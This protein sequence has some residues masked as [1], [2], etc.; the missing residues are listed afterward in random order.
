MNMK[1]IQ[2]AYIE[3]DFLLSSSSIKSFDIVVLNGVLAS[4][5]KNIENEL[6]EY[7]KEGGIMI[8]ILNPEAFYEQIPF[9]DL[10]PATVKFSD[11]FVKIIPKNYAK[12]VTLLGPNGNLTV[13]LTNYFNGTILYITT[14]R[15]MYS[16]GEWWDSS[17]YKSAEAFWDKLFRIILNK[18]KALKII[19]AESCKYVSIIFFAIPFLFIKQILRENLE[20]RKNKTE[21]VIQINIRKKYIS[22]IAVFLLYLLIGLLIVRFQLDNDVPL[23][24]EILMYAG[25]VQCVSNYI[26]KFKSPPSWNTYWWF[27]QPID[28]SLTYYKIYTLLLAP[29]AN[30]I[31]AISTVK[32]MLIISLALGS[33]GTYLVALYFIKNPYLSIFSGIFYEINV[34]TFIEILLWGHLEIAMGYAFSPFVF[35]MLLKLA[36]YSYNRKIKDIIYT[37]SIYGVLASLLLLTQSE[38]RTIIY[39]IILVVMPFFI[40]EFIIIFSTDKKYFL[41]ILTSFIVFLLHIGLIVY[42]LYYI[43]LM[44]HSVYFFISPTKKH[45]SLDITIGYTPTLLQSMACLG[46]GVGH[47]AKYEALG[48]DIGNALLSFLPISLTLF[49]IISFDRKM[50]FLLGS[51]IWSILVTS[52]IYSPI[53]KPYVLLFQY[54]PYIQFMKVPFRNLQSI[55]F[56][57]S[58]LFVNGLG[59]FI[60]ILS[61]IFKFKQFRLV[62]LSIIILATLLFFL[63]DYILIYDPYY[64]RSFSKIPSDVHVL[65]DIM[66]IIYEDGNEGTILFIPIYGSPISLFNEIPDYRS[67]VPFSTCPWQTGL[68]ASFYAAKWSLRTAVGANAL[69]QGLFRTN[70]YLG[71][72]VGPAFFYGFKKQFIEGLSNMFTIKY[73]II[74]KKIIPKIYIQMVEQL[75]AQNIL[76]KLY[77]DEN[78]ILLKIKNV[79]NIDRY[80]LISS[81]PLIIYSGS[82]LHGIEE[83]SF[84][85]INSTGTPYI[86][87]PDPIDRIDVSEFEKLINN[88]K[89]LVIQ[90]SSF[91]DLITYFTII[92]LSSR[93]KIIRIPLESES[94]DLWRPSAYWQPAFDA[95]CAGTAKIGNLT[96]MLNHIEK[97]D[98]IIL[99]RLFNAPFRGKL[100]IILDGKII[101]HSRPNETLGFSYITIGPLREAKILQLFNEESAPN[102]I[103]ELFIIN[104]KDYLISRKSIEEKLKRLLSDRSLDVCYIYHPS[105]FRRVGYT[106]ETSYW[107]GKDETYPPVASSLVL[108]PDSMIEK[109]FYVF[110]NDTL[111]ITLYL[112]A[113]SKE[114][115]KL[116]PR[117]RLEI[118][119]D[120]RTY[121]ILSIEFINETFKW[122]PINIHIPCSNGKH[123]LTIRNYNGWN[124]LAL[125]TIGDCLR[126]IKN[127]DTVRSQ[128]Y[129]KELD[130]NRYEINISITANAYDLSS[131]LNTSLVVV[132]NEQYFPGWQLENSMFHIPINSIFNGFI[133]NINSSISTHALKIYYDV[134]TY[135]KYGYMGVFVYSLVLI[136]FPVVKKA[137]RYD[138]HYRTNTKK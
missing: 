59:I 23:S 73:L 103:D 68:I 30:I 107:A 61:K 50:Y 127:R 123:T 95:F 33:F 57:Q 96:L 88:F 70:W 10:L 91:E 65:D 36:E 120:N 41:N 85:K 12:N 118:L 22:K 130:S 60:T 52:G 106:Y 4:R 21:I 32:L 114:Y 8:I 109:D 7:V 111:S 125:I 100:K 115:N 122:I 44:S 16:G 131:A 133:L 55:C 75:Y 113:V 18:E 84:L 129:W 27:G 56:L 14:P 90:D 49:N 38:F 69:A 46:Y 126:I 92:D 34:F 15:V 134:P 128:F 11:G 138:I 98:F 94:N 3:A 76:E 137:K 108:G 40:L 6:K 2:T 28:I 110:S 66:Q 136:S 64:T 51:L 81:S 53:I 42:V 35:L 39:F 47:V 121:A 86:F 74:A 117:G 78:F 72:E 132:L 83:L 89:V 102:D 116:W 124:D 26:S 87:I 71:T 24:Y 43:P 119:L 77:E 80:I 63:Y 82:Y 31:G 104:Y 62:K 25:P 93:G 58:I 67:Y 79:A 19:I 101:Y 105:G 97:E 17:E 48:I 37:A 54:L 1:N 99:I 29:F 9:A 45:Y 5:I 13:F 135:L 112:A 20:N